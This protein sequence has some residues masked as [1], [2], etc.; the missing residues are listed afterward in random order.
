MIKGIDLNDFIASL[1]QDEQDAI[2]LEYQ[3][4]R[5]E[6]FALQEIRKAVGMSQE[7]LADALEM[8]QGNLSKLEKRADMHVSTLRRYVEALGG[9]LHIMAALPDKPMIEIYGLSGNTK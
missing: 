2:E 6:Y 5:E 7:Q 1:S 3:E 9:K 4:V 8:N